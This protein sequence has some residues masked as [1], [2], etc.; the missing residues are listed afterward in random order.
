MQYISSKQK[1]ANFIEEFL[2]PALK[3]KD[4]DYEKTIQ[5]IMSQCYCSRNS[6]EEGIKQFT[7]HQMEEVRFLTYPKEKIVSLLQE[8]RAQEKK[9]EEE[10]KQCL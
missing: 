2:I 5:A 9:V 7:P 8:I 6:A 10:L 3:I 4:L 1:I